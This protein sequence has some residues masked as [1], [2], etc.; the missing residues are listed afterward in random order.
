MAVAL[1]HVHVSPHGKIAVSAH[2]IFPTMPDIVLG[3][4]CE[5]LQFICGD[6]QYLT[7]SPG[8]S[9]LPVDP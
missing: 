2:Y 9:T 8:K 3:T 1:I 5:S 6:P 7:E 4:C